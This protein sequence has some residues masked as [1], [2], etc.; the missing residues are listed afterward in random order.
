[1]GAGHRG[2]AAD[3][4]DAGR[5]VV[6]AIGPGFATAVYANGF[7]IG[8]AVPAALTIPLVL[9]LVG[10]SWPASFVVLVGAGRGDRSC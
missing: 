6:R 4:A 2:A 1:M 5:R 7:L 3:L 10:G 8:E 9:P